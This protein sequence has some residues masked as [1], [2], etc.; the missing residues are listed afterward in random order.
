MICLGV[1][2]GRVLVGTSKDRDLDLREVWTVPLDWYSWSVWWYSRRCNQTR[3]GVMGK[4]GVYVFTNYFCAWI[5]ILKWTSKGKRIFNNHFLIL[6]VIKLVSILNHFFLQLIRV[7]RNLKNI[8]NIGEKI[9]YRGK[10]G[11]FKMIFSLGLSTF[12]TEMKVYVLCLQRQAFMMGSRL[13]L[14]KLKRR[15]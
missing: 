7:E 3:T 15:I 12:K 14:S 8:P 13:T 6:L 2:Q 5:K 10:G 1:H 11:F 4:S 9:F